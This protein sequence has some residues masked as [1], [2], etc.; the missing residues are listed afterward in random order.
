M[1][2]IQDAVRGSVRQGGP[3]EVKGGQNGHL[4]KKGLVRMP[5]YVFP[6]P[7]RGHASGFGTACLRPTVAAHGGRAPRRAPGPTT[8][9]NDRVCEPHW[10]SPRPSFMTHATPAPFGV[11]PPPWPS[12]P[13]WTPPPRGHQGWVREN[14]KHG[15]FE[16]NVF[17][18]SKTPGVLNSISFIVVFYFIPCFHIFLFHDPLSGS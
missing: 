2:T 13:S 18:D 4:S 9:P 11:M 6:T 1:C 17:F 7:L 14:K 16:P 3:G 5:R 8:I 15:F 10:S 12:P